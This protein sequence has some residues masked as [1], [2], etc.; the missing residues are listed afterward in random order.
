[1]GWGQDNKRDIDTSKVL[2]PLTLCRGKDL[3]EEAEFR[4]F[5]C[6]ALRLE[7]ASPPKKNLDSF[8]PLLPFSIRRAPT[9]KP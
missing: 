3:D 4:G 6:S 7:A 5:A 8:H 1:M 9:A 2:K